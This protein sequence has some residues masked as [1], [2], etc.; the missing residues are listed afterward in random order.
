MA[1]A[2]KTKKIHK[3]KR[4]FQTLIVLVFFAVASVPH[5][6]SIELSLDSTYNQE[7]W[8]LN[9]QISDKRKSVE[10]LRQQAAVYKKSLAGKQREIASLSYQISTLNQTITKISLEKE[11]LELSIEEI[12]LQIKNSQLKI[13]ATEEQIADQ[14]ES[15]ADLV[16]TLYIAD[17]QNN[18]LY[19]LASTNN[20]GDYLSQLQSLQGIHDDVLLGIDGLSN[21]KVALI[22]EQ[23]DLDAQ[24]ENIKG[25]QV[26]LDSKSL[27]LEDQKLVKYSLVND[28][29]G[30]EQKYQQLL[31]DLKDEQS[32]INNDIVSL[33]QVAREKLNRQLQGQE[34]DLGS[35]PMAWPVPSR[36]I[37]SY[38][39]DPDY[40]YRNIF[41]HPALDI[42]SPQGAPIYAA[43]SG[44]VARA[45][46]AGLSYSYI[47]L[48][49]DNGLSTV[50]GH[51]SKIVVEEGSFVTQGQIIG[52][53]GGTPRTAGAGNLTTGPQLHFEIRLNG[54][55]V[56]PLN[57]LPQ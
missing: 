32:R 5:A 53:S 18:V 14:K 35:G 37:T 36:V 13:Q 19:L 43:A 16:R 24:K 28:T 40:P 15:V 1:D 49:H 25:L 22:G 29:R 6:Q 30:E 45:K 44:Y 54:I 56:N 2:T 27:S 46:D 48:I 57:Y 11:A 8:E 39:H 55:P 50:Y 31:E 23:S 26:D 20:L 51:V 12:N 9:Q 34:R 4:I 52:N 7:I 3:H 47:M 41:E 42:K 17:K 21:L 10:A 38:F 33:E